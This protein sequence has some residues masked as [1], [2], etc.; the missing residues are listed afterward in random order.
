VVAS[1]IGR[2][3]Q[4]ATG[5]A[6]PFVWR[7]DDASRILASPRRAT[8]TE[9]PEPGRSS[10]PRRPRTAT[11]SKGRGCHRRSGA[12]A[13]G[14]RPRLGGS[15]GRHGPAPTGRSGARRRQPPRTAGG[16]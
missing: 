3:T 10:S 12:M 16:G 4:L 5:V 7:P 1:S 2:G 6:A 9:P 11:E 15:R 13:D 8:L 14:P